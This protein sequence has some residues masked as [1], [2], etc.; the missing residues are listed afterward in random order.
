[1][2]SAT[3]WVA[4]TSNGGVRCL[5]FDG[6]NDTVSGSIPTS[7][8]N[9]A[10][11]VTLAGWMYKPS[12]GTTCAFGPIASIGGA[13]RFVLLWN[14]DGNLLFLTE[15]GGT[16]IGYFALTGGG[17]HH[18]ALVYDGT[19]ATNAARA[20]CYLDVSRSRHY[21]LAQCLHH[22]I[23]LLMCLRLAVMR[24][25]VFVQA[26]WMTV[27]Y[28]LVCCH[29]PKS[30]PSHPSEDIQDKTTAGLAMRWLVVPLT[31]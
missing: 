22:S 2:D 31:R 12:Q 11:K 10:T 16:A 23:A 13:N 9:G 25:R 24:Q 27:G 6:S 14:S 7:V 1:M 19:Q 21:S 4:D 3:D 29:K 17:W 28:L 26:D 20:V 18:L 5:D 8:L 30:V 15:S